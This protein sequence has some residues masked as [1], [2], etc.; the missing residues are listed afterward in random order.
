MSS[1]TLWRNLAIL[2]FFVAVAA[3]FS[4]ADVSMKRHVKERGAVSGEWTSQVRIKGLKMRIEATKDG[5]DFISVWDLSSGEVYRLWPKRKEFSIVDLKTASEK[6]KGNFLPEK[7]SRVVKAT[8]KKMQI[9]GAICEEYRL[10]LQAPST[11]SHGIVWIL[12]DSGTVCVSQTMPEGIEIANFVLEAKKR[13][14]EL[15]AEALSP[16]P[17]RLGSYYYGEQSNVVMLAAHTESRVDGPGSSV[18]LSAATD[19]TYSLTVSEIKS[20]PIPDEEF[21]IPAGWKQVKDSSPL[22]KPINSR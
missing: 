17:T 11:P 14:Y 7:L 4:K 1:K 13:G 3:D 6:R 10:D 21:Q 12:R 16:S 2:S 15:A 20:E 19:I 22:G 8:G 5:E 9:E 18:E